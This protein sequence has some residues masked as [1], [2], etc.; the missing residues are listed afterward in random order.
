MESQKMNRIKIAALFW[1][2]CKDFRTT[3]YWC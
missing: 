1:Y 3:W 2:S